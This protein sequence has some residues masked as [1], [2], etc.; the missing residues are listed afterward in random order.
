MQ[1]AVFTGTHTDGIYIW[2]LVALDMSECRLNGWFSAD[3]MHI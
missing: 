1:A 3:F 2:S